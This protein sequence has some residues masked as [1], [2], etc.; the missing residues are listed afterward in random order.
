MSSLKFTRLT[1]CSSS[2]TRW[3][4]AERVRENEENEARR[5]LLENQRQRD[6]SATAD[7]SIPAP[8]SANFDQSFYHAALLMAEAARNAQQAFSSA[9]SAVNRNNQQRDGE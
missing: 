2:S 8:G 6:Y 7:D 1:D 5:P 9:A 3:E 4:R